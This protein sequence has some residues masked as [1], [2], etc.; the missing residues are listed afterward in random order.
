MNSSPSLS[1]R[2]LVTG[3]SGYVGSRLVRRLAADGCDVH[4]VLRPIS[5]RASLRAVAD[6]VHVHVH[7]GS[8]DGLAAIIGESRPE[9]V[10]HLASLFLPQHQPADVSALVTSNI[11]FSTQLVE[12]MATHD[13]RH[14]VNTG[15]SWQHHCNADYL[16]VNL[17]AATKQAF[18]DVLTYYCDAH[19]L[20]AT[21]LAL[22]DTYGPDDP[23]KKLIALLWQAASSGAPLLL[24]PGEQLLDMVHIDDVV[25]AFVL[26]ARQLPAQAAGHVRYGLSSGRPMSLRDLVAKF[27]QAT[28]ERLPVT[29]GGRQYRPREVMVPWNRYESLPG[30]SPHV[31]FED[32]IVQTRPQSVDLHA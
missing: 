18:E 24:S 7:D 5:D 2:M 3:A 23:R 9:V 12:A 27:E 4:V 15:T 1:V 14:L 20:K 8:T 6:H 19:N 10:F 26:A 11:L 32:G 13:V 28:G 22:F 29:W 25:N 16:P 17:Y 30:W 21:T 31:P